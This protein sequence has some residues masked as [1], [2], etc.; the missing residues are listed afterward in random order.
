MAQAI[1]GA[2]A[3]FRVPASAPGRAKP[4][5]PKTPP[6][7]QIFEGRI[8]ALHVLSWCPTPLPTVPPTQVHLVI[9]IEPAA[10][11]P[12]L[13]TSAAPIVVLRFKGP[14]TLDRL[15]A[16]LQEHR[17]DVWGEIQPSREES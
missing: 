8:E 6:N 5:M 17:S 7:V 16:I 14:G 13:S 11:V 1:A 3:N 12:R 15:I 9:E 4:T 10:G 2:D